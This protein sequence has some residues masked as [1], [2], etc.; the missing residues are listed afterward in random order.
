MLRSINTSND[1][2]KALELLDVLYMQ[3][4]HTETTAVGLS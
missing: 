4:L 1:P 3:M 2:G